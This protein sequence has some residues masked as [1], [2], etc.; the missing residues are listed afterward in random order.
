MGSSPSRLCGPDSIANRSNPAF[1]QLTIDFQ[2]KTSGT[3][4]S[5]PWYVWT[6]RAK[7]RK[8][9]IVDEKLRYESCKRKKCFGTVHRLKTI[10]TSLTVSVFSVPKIT[11]PL[12]VVC[13][14]I[15]EQNKTDS[16]W[17]WK[18][19]PTSDSCVLHW[20]TRICFDRY[21]LQ[22]PN[23]KGLIPFSWKNDQI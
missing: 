15:E 16:V 10:Y 12:R 20:N 4:G 9:E 5:K 7:N 22:R 18:R 14:S 13:F 19:M 3:V 1:R 2:Y 21:F 23:R 17:Q 6:N 8:K 11:A